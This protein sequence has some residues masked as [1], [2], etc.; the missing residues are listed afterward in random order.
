MVR[1]EVERLHDRGCMV[2]RGRAEGFG[3]GWVPGR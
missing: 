3:K 1:E 2:K